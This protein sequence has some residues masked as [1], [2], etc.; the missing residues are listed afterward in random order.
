MD[1]TGPKELEETWQEETTMVES[2]VPWVETGTLSGED[3]VL[4][5]P[6]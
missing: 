5:A 2:P 3:I 4:D 1:E 6:G